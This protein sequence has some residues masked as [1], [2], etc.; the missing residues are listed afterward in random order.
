MEAKQ[1]TDIEENTL[2]LILLNEEIS[3]CVCCRLYGK[4][5]IEGWQPKGEQKNSKKRV[6]TSRGGNQGLLR[7]ERTILTASKGNFLFR[8]YDS[9]DRYIKQYRENHASTCMERYSQD[10]GGL[11]LGVDLPDP[12]LP[13]IASSRFV[14]V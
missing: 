6:D 2:K 1:L 5:A 12:Y 11:V 3:P 10:G 9:L 13:K 14:D 8:H 7:R 4:S